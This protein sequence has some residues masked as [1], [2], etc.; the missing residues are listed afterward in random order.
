MSAAK[1]HAPARGRGRRDGLA[2]NEE[3]T[4][5][6]Q[7]IGR[8]AGTR[9]GPVIEQAG[10]VPTCKRCACGGCP[11]SRP[12]LASRAQLVA[13]RREAQEAGDGDQA[14]L[15]TLALD[16]DH[17]ALA[18]CTVVIVGALGN[19]EASL[20]TVGAIAELLGLSWGCYLM[21]VTVTA[22]DW[23]VHAVMG[24][25]AV[26]W[27]ANPTSDDEETVDGKWHCARDIEA[28]LRALGG[29]E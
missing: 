1:T 6:G 8:F 23:R 19:D 7:T 9:S 15:C 12:L 18:R 20:F 17:D 21:R 2:S 10:K 3:R 27:W 4:R 28:G 29:V 5:C 11:M 25:G 26:S 16:G 13:L 24:D 22:G 14:R